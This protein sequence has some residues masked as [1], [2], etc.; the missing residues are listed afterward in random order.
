M[1]RT[2][3]SLGNPLQG[4]VPDGSDPDD[5][6][7]WEDW[8]DDQWHWE[9]KR[10]NP[11]VRV[12]YFKLIRQYDAEEEGSEIGRTNAM[13][14]KEYAD[15]FFY[16]TPALTAKWGMSVLYNPLYSKRKILKGLSQH[17]GFQRRTIGAHTLDAINRGQTSW[18]NLMGLGIAITFDPN[19]PLKH[20][21]DGLEEY[22]MSLRNS[23]AERDIERHHTLKWLT[24]LRVHDAKISG[25][26]WKD[27]AQL[28]P[29]T[30]VKTPQAA[31]DCFRQALRLIEGL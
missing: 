22:L 20:Q 17:L 13:Q 8:D 30:N 29:T 4:G 28:L 3:K 5:Y 11:A 16:L 1:I 24:Y 7:G 10:R 6:A 18:F 9:F 23:K 14:N 25:A 31:R 2:L 21:L 27:C 12:E 15:V 26:S 19:A